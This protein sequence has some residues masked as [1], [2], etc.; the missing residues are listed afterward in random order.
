M[1]VLL[2]QATAKTSASNTIARSVDALRCVASSPAVAVPGSCVAAGAC[3][4]ASTSGSSPTD[5]NVAPF[6]SCVVQVQNAR[7]Q[8]PALVLLVATTLAGLGASVRAE[9]LRCEDAKGNVSYT[10]SSCPAGT[11]PQRRVS[12]KEPVS[13]LPD[14]QGNADRSRAARESTDGGARRPVAPPPPTAPAAPATPTAPVGPTGAVIIDG[15]GGGPEERS[16][17]QR[18]DTD[19]G[20]DPVVA[21][22]GYNAYG[23]PYAGAQQRPPRPPRDMRPRIRNCD[24]A[25]GCTDTQ[26][27][28]YNQNTGKLDRYQSIDGKTCPPVGSTVVCR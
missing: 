23:Y 26:G 4:G 1:A 14:P 2:N 28:T 27:N 21:Q 3:A 13:V 15:R 18:W 5:S 25:T 7:M 9:V 11:K 10:D 24:P 6:P 8:S 16:D 12:T 19:L 20:G 17:A 22:E